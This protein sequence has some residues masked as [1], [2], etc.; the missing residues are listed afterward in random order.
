VNDYVAQVNAASRAF[1][2][3]YRTIDTAFRR[4]S[5]APA[6]AEKQLPEVRSAARE[7]TRL[8]TRIA[9][10]PA[11]EQAAELRRR[12]IAFF[13]Q[14]EAVGWELVAVSGYVPRLT[15][16]EATL[17][18]AGRRMRAALKASTSAAAQ[19]EALRTYARSMRRTASLLD[20]IR[21]P[22]LFAASHEAQIE[23]LRATAARISRLAGAL[24]GSD[25]DAVA[26][27][28]RALGTGT[29]GSADAAREAVRAYNRRIERIRTLA[30]QLE[31]E[32]LRLSETLD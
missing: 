11:P 27:A 17:D 29:S 6:Q 2:A 20:A 16:A 9:A 5:F 4:F 25:R 21:A 8:R 23:R 12:V 1:A 13:R 28:L 7:L 30:E 18:P 26:K 32:R 31:R 24:E 15:R 3:D 14:Q 10:V 19:A 22:Q